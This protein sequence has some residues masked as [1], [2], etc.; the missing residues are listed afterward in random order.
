MVGLTMKHLLGERAIH[1]PMHGIV[2]RMGGGDMVVC[3]FLSKVDPANP[4]L[5]GAS[6]THIF[7]HGDMIV[8]PN[9]AFASNHLRG[10]G[11]SG[12]V[13]SEAMSSPVPWMEHGR[14]LLEPLT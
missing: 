13:Q 12:L 5:M 7:F 6:E 1:V 9:V 8:R 11:L 2:Q 3:V 10:S 4:L 14:I